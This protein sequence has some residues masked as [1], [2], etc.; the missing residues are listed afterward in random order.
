MAFPVI[1]AINQNGGL[2]LAV[3]D[4]KRR[5]VNCMPMLQDAEQLE[6]VQV[7]DGDVYSL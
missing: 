7:N 3:I 6:R 4:S 5:S 2:A 1:L